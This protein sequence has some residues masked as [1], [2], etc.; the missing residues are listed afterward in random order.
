MADATAKAYGKWFTPRV[1]VGGALGA[2]SYSE[3]GPYI[4]IHPK[5]LTSPSLRVLVAHELGH[6]VLG[7][8]GSSLS[9]TRGFQEKR[10][11]DAN[12][13]AVRILVKLGSSEPDAL[14][15]M[16]DALA[17]IHRNSLPN[18]AR[19]FGHYEACTEI[20]D[21]LGRFPRWRDAI[22]VAPALEACVPPP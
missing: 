4:Y 6:Y 3:S 1:V 7:H 5:T 20:R 21:L 9:Y 14:R 13:E 12:T 22:T 8:H 11:L 17:W 18:V 16:Y 2:A 15:L 19:M 10:E